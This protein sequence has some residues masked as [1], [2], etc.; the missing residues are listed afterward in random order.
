MN[1]NAFGM[2]LKW[3]GKENFLKKRENLPSLPDFGPKTK[4]YPAAQH[5]TYVL[6]LSFGLAAKLARFP[7]LLAAVRQAG[8]P[9]NAT[10]PASQAHHVLSLSC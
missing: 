9:G 6:P 7:S 5:P 4:P 10:M 1:S 2:D 8:L 3:L